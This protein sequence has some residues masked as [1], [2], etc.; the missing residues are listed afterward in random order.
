FT[1]TGLDNARGIVPI[2]G[3]FVDLVVPPG[4][5]GGDELTLRDV[6]IDQP[7]I[8]VGD[9]LTGGVVHVEY[10]D[11]LL[12]DV[13]VTGLE[14]TLTGSVSALRG[15]F[16]SVLASDLTVE[17]LSVVD[18]VV[19][20]APTAQ[21]CFYEGGVV[22]ASTNGQIEVRDF[23]V[24]GGAFDLDCPLQAFAIGSAA[25][26]RNATVLGGGWTLADNTVLASGA[27]AFG[28][29]LVFQES[30]NLLVGD[31]GFVDNVIDVDAT[32]LAAAQ[33]PLT[34][35][36]LV[37]LPQI[38]GLDAIGNLVRAVGPPEAALAYGGALSTTSNDRLDIEGID[39]RGNEVVGDVAFG[40]AIFV[41]SPSLLVDD[42]VFAGNVVGGAGATRAFG[43][44]IHLDTPG[45]NLGL[46]HIDFVGNR[47]EGSIE[48]RGGAVSSRTA[49]GTLIPNVLHVSFVD[50]AVAGT[51]TVGAALDSPNAPFVRH[52]NTFGN[53]GAEAYPGYTPSSSSG[54]LFVEPEYVDVSGADARTWDLRLRPGSPLVDAG[55]PFLTDPDGTPPDIGAY[56]GPNAP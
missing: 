25:Y 40:G 11:T 54:N 15:A 49:S 56:G 9:E 48:A 52:S 23:D 37:V 32:T 50:N 2:P 18:T 12:R 19:A 29:G 7:R 55:L 36:P 5:S 45:G 20:S 38:T 51:T 4:L 34:L 31:L 28:Y 8:T 44:A 17:G 3:A 27:Q 35:A 46:E 14:A 41:L 16:L 26:F 10:G 53:G 30:G 1:V 33:G 21:A 6:V 43:G 13:E 42:S 22:Y 47:A 24:S 39:A